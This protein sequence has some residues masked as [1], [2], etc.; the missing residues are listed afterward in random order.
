MLIWYYHYS[1]F[2]LIFLIAAFQDILEIDVQ[3]VSTSLNFS[4]ESLNEDQRS[5]LQNERAGQLYVYRYSNTSVVL[6]TRNASL[7]GADIGIGSAADGRYRCRAENVNNGTGEKELN[8]IIG[9][10]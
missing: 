10:E 8:I 1:N 6:A 7:L 9:S 4:L 2:I 3:S 5:V